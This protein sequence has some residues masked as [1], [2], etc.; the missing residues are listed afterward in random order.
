MNKFFK[1]LLVNGMKILFMVFL[2]KFHKVYNFIE[3]ITN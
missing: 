3:N 1:D 2:M